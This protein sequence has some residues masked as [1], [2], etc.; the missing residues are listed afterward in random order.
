MKRIGLVLSLIL[1]YIISFGQTFVPSPGN[2]I[3]VTIGGSQYKV[4]TPDD[5]AT[6]DVNDLYFLVWFHGDGEETASS[7]ENTV[8]GKWV[9]SG[10]P[11]NGKVLLN[12]GDT[13]RLI[14]F[15]IP[16]YG[17]Q[18]GKY[19]AAIKD[20]LRSFSRLGVSL[21]GTAAVPNSHFSIGGF[22]GGPGRAISWLRDDTVAVRSMF[23]RGV[24]ISPTWISAPYTWSN[25]GNWFVF[26]NRDDPNG[27]TPSAAAV[28]LYQNLSGT[29]DSLSI[30]VPG[31]HCN[32][33][34]D[35]AMT[36][37]GLNSHTGGTALTNRIRRLID[38]DDGIGVPVNQPPVANAGTNQT[39]TLPTSSVT[40][41]GSAS[42][43]PDGTIVG[44]L[45]EQV[46]GPTSATIVSPTSVSTSI[47]G[48]SVEGTYV[49]RLTVTDNDGASSNDEVT[50][51]VQTAPAYG[52]QIGTQ[53]EKTFNGKKF[54]LFVPDTL[55]LPTRK[56]FFVFN[57]VDSSGKDKAYAESRGLAK[58]IANGWPGY[59]RLESGD[60][61]FF[62]VATQIDGITLKNDMENVLQWCL[63][64][65]PRHLFDTSKRHR[66]IMTAI[67]HGARE[68]I[69]YM[70]NK[71][72][73]LGQGGAL[74][75]RDAFL[76]FTPIAASD[77]G[78]VVSST[79]WVTMKQP[80]RSWW[81][82]GTSA[83]YPYLS[84]YTTWAYDSALKYNGYPDTK[85][86]GVS[87]VG[88]NSTLFDSAYSSNGSTPDNNV[89][90]WW[91]DSVFVPPY[92]P[93]T[94]KIE[95]SP[96]MM[97][98]LVGTIGKA[99][100][101]LVDGD[102]TESAYPNFT[103]GYIISEYYTE[104]IWLMLDSFINTPK[105]RVF[106]ANSIGVK[107]GVQFFYGNSDTSR[108]SDIYW[109]NLPNNQWAYIDSFNTRQYSDSIRWVKL[110]IN[111]VANELRE[112][113]LY[114][115]TLGPAPNILPAASAEPDDPGKFFQGLGKYDSD[116]L[117][118]DAAHSI[119]LQYSMNWI[120]T[121]KS[122]AYGGTWTNG[123]TIGFAQ[124]YGN[125]E[126]ST[127]APAKRNG[128][129][130]WM[131]LADTRVAFEN[132]LGNPHGKDM[133]IGADSTD[134]ASWVYVKETHFMAAAWFGFNPDVNTD[135]FTMTDVV[136]NQKGRGY[137][138]YMEVGNEDGQWWNGSK[139]FH[140]PRVQYLKV[141]AGYQGIKEAD[142]NMKVI[143]GSQ[144]GLN[145][146]RFKSF[147]FVHHWYFPNEP[148]PADAFAFNEY[149]TNA[150]GQHV[151]TTHGISPEQF[152][153]RAKLDSN[154]AIRNKYYPGLE[155]FLT[156]FGY[157]GNFYR[158][159]GGNLD[160]VNHNS[161][162]QVPDV[163]GVTREIT[164]SRWTMRE[165][166]HIAASRWSRAMQYT[167]KNIPGGDFSAT[168]FTYDIELSGN[169]STY[170]PAY[171]QP[172]CGSRWTTGG[173]VTLPTE[174]YWYMTTRSYRLANY[175]AW[176]TVIT[177]GDSTG[178]WVQRYTHVT[179]PDSLIYTVW[180]GTHDNSTTSN[181]EIT[182]PNVV[183][184]TLVTPA[185]GNKF[186]TET[187]LTVNGDKVTIPTVTEDVQ[188]LLIK[189]SSGPA[190]TSHE[191]KVRGRKIIYIP[192]N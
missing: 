159:T 3:T 169:P 104:G 155:L 141:R 85:I 64:S 73:E 52:F 98:D 97:F 69:R 158:K 42:Y 38:P 189:T 179:N 12:N 177:E 45:W 8:M 120:D 186:G 18:P 20:A 105:V 13:A 106:N 173:W 99:T 94:H 31:C 156:E 112:I 142:P 148:F 72:G 95:L 119:R 92:Y 102:T 19:G 1:S 121:A 16:H 127:F 61:A 51:T 75:F 160:T 191:M 41:N 187:P 163:V 34:W 55:Q 118:D 167:K 46:V 26:W 133:P 117:F 143:F 76:N 17:A 164:K 192:R 78:S 101:K 28:G 100:H 43:D 128:K 83:G 96:D 150:G 182:I 77:Y 136:G 190:P 62:T 170:L 44:Y 175:N 81:W 113:Q 33:I 90:V 188:Y 176:A 109:G 80:F 50:I 114:G 67:G 60:T 4:F 152:R 111:G 103:D 140:S 168:G 71:F 56:Y 139:R 70:M 91:A 14:I 124:R 180:L 144:P 134:P 172:F 27:G 135:G 66:N 35:S 58:K 49:F 79:G 10:G 86:T 11:W 171:M 32:T 22:S 157:D 122:A 147:W 183:S 129:D 36:I 151:G 5:Y 65:L 93:P 123:R 54:L 25:S 89:F 82:H 29:K 184:A 107:L 130:F 132:P 37:T 74:K 131:Y 178:V 7:T 153:L 185:I 24:F 48:L 63:D 57:M 137:F 39:I 6:C 165:Y 125:S 9:K 126:L 30:S 154:I 162:Y 47:N 68:Q 174:F 146:S 59:Q 88:Y 138:R 161:N 87:G 115:N 181:Y 166:E 108:H 2:N 145:P 149:C 21:N 84:L 110:Y 40:V 53:I 116:S 15:S 23:K